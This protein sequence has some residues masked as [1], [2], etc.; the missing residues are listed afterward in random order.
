MKNVYAHTHCP[1]E[2]KYGNFE[3][4]ICDPLNV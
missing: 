2:A 1:Y 3:I 4:P